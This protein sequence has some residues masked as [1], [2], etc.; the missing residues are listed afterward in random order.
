[1][2]DAFAPT[3]PGDFPLPDRAPYSI[4]VD[5][6][7][8]RSDMAAGNS[9]QRRMF[10]NMPQMFGLSFKLHTA[11]L[12]DWQNWVNDNAYRWFYSCP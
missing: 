10:T 9:R 6:G 12:A 2:P 11:E 3:Y 7:V 5:M 1:M 8:V 4:A